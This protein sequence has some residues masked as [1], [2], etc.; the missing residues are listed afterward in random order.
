V[1][2]ET[3]DNQLDFN[4][5]VIQGHDIASFDWQLVQAREIVPRTCTDPIRKVRYVVWE[6]MNYSV[7]LR[8]S[9]DIDIYWNLQRVDSSDR[10]FVEDV[11]ISY[12]QI[13]VVYKDP[14]SKRTVSEV[15]KNNLN[16][17]MRVDKM[18]EIP[19]D[20]FDIA[21]TFYQ[22]VKANVNMFGSSCLIRTNLWVS[23]GKFVSVYNI[24]KNKWVNNCKFADTVELFRMKESEELFSTGIMYP[25]GKILTDVK[26]IVDEGGSPDGNYSFEDQ[27]ATFQL[28]GK[29]I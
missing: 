13:F 2:L 29:P 18:E 11:E 5:F 23:H 20:D 16:K 28:P 6:G 27:K 1:L 10:L 12:D 8:Q 17:E 9:Q 22:N 24:L 21:K 15:L 25:S 14:L 4:K 26:R 19:Y 3:N 7:A